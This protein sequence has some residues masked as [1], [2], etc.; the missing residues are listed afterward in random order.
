VRH[1]AVAEALRGL[2]A[3]IVRAARQ[4]ERTGTCDYAD[5]PR[6][7]PEGALRGGLELSFAPSPG[8]GNSEGG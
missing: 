8:P 5:D 1:K 2:G 4:V 7:G 6:P 3:E